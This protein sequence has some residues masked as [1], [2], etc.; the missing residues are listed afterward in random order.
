MISNNLIKLLKIIFIGLFVLSVGLNV[1]LL[2]KEDI[3]VNTIIKEITTEKIDTI[4]DTIKDIVPIVKY[5]TRIKTVKDTLIQSI[6][7]H[8]TVK[9]EAYIPIT[10]KVY[11][12][13]TTYKAWISGYKQNLDSITIYNKIITKN[14]TIVRKPTITIGPTIVGGYDPIN[15]K[16][17]GMIGIGVTYNLF[18]IGK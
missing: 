7:N 14:N 5:E 18:Q 3:K 13:D 17:G 2:T 12:N 6:V 8:D 16:F 10:Q 11:S 9:V 4:N 1:Y 15:N